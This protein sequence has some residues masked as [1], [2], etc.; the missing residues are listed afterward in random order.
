MIEKQLRRLNFPQESIQELKQ[1]RRFIIICDGYDESRLSVN[2][3]LANAFNQPGQWI[4]KMIVSCRSTHVGQDYHDRFRPMSTDRYN[5]NSATTDLFE[6]ATIAPFSP[7]QVRK[8]V[9]QHVQDPEVQKLFRGSPVWTA[10][11]YMYKL[12]Q[13]PNLLQLVANPFLLAMALRA[14]P[15]VVKG[16]MDLSSVKITRLQLYETFINQWLEVNKQ[17]LTSSFQS[18]DTA[19]A[20]EELLEEGFILA[21]I[22]YSKNLAAA[23]YNHQRGNPVVRYSHRSDKA[24]WKAQFFGPAAEITLLRESTPLTRAG[25]LHRFIHR[26]L[27]E[28]FYFRHISEHAFEY[29]AADM[30]L[31]RKYARRP[32]FTIRMRDTAERIRRFFIGIFNP[33]QQLS[34]HPLKNVDLTREPEILQ[35][36]V[37]HMQEESQYGSR[38]QEIVDHAVSRKGQITEAVRNARRILGQPEF[39]FLEE[40]S[41][42][43]LGL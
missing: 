15:V 10:D 40:C 33:P 34:D 2:L 43:D 8:Y 31:Y 7:D 42:F 19:E 3:H 4:T 16:E 21:A 12:T 9:E 38:L 27:L 24:T 30:N 23:M 25:S 32:S 39:T 17:R 20:L 14:L 13:I 37:D 1:H 22:D 29:E 18:T 11:E 5:M 28:Y 26:S 36:L 41:F 6:E 35:F